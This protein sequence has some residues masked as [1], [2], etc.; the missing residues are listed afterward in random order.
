MATSLSNDYPILLSNLSHSD[1]LL[2]RRPRSLVGLHTLN[3]FTRV[4][5]HG[6][7]P[8]FGSPPPEYWRICVHLY[9]K[10]LMLPYLGM[11]FLPFSLSDYLFILLHTPKISFSS[12]HTHEKFRPLLGRLMLPSPGLFL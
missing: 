4:L 3:V 8:A 10:Y 2:L 5:F 9:I 1:L 7:T 12:H 6:T 11:A